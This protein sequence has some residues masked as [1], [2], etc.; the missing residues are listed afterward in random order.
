MRVLPFVGGLIFSVAAAGC[1]T[2]QGATAT[3]DSGPFV[4]PDLPKLAGQAATCAGAREKK[5]TLEAREATVDLGMGVRFAAWTYNGALPGPVLEACEGDRVT[6][7]LANHAN[8]SHGLDA[9][10]FIPGKY[11]FRVHMNDPALMMFN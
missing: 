9:S 10:G 1:V 8:T 11:P 6:I 3:G 7:T 4:A 2:P 5:F